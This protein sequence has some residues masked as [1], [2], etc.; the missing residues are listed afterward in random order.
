MVGASAYLRGLSAHATI[1]PEERQPAA[2]VSLVLYVIG[3]GALAVV[4]RLPGVSHKHETVMLLLALGAM[5]LSPVSYQLLRNHRT[6]AW[7]LQLLQCTALATV[8]AAVAASGGA[9]S[10]FWF[11]VFIPAVFCSYFYGRPVAMCYLLACVLVQALPFVY[12]QRAA[13]GLFLA[14]LVAGAPA[15]VALGVSI[16][17]G[18]RR[19]WALRARAEMLASEQFALRRVATAVV[20][21]DAAENIYDMV[22]GEIA[23]LLHCAGAGIMRRQDETTLVVVGSRGDNEGGVYRPGTVVPARPGSDILRALQTGLPVRIDDH[24]DDSPAAAL[25]YRSSIVSPVTVGGGTWGLLAVAD[26]APAAFDAGDELTLSEFGDLLATAIASAEE[27]AQ[28]A[29]QA[30]S[31][32]L[33]GLANQRA[34][35]GRLDAELAR[36]ARHESPLSI[37]LIDI[38]HFKEINDNAGHDIG[39]A[40]L[41][42]V[43]AALNSFARAEDTLARVG[44][45]EFAWVLPDTTREQALVAVER[46]RRLIAAA[47]P[48]PYRITIS[49]GICDTDSAIDPTDLT[50]LADSALYWSKAHGRNQSWIYDPAVVDELTGQQR[51]DRIERSQAIEG[52]RAL[53]RSREA[54]DGATR[55]HSERVATLAGALARRAGWDRSAEL[56]LREAALFHEIGSIAGPGGSGPGGTEL[57]EEDLEGFRGVAELSARIVDGVLDPQQVAWIAGQYARPAAEPVCGPVNGSALLT[58][59]DLWDTMTALRPNSSEQALAECER[60]ADGRLDDRAVGALLALHR[61]GELRP[62]VP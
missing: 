1:D 56:L 13:H 5:V 14:Q 52:L 33:T 23:R 11:Y 45:D 59:A 39:D 2:V 54:R 43:A 27:R 55:E 50:R 46:A 17:S 35:Q 29:E 25:G 62:T 9:T 24:P 51:A 21:G 16:S 28:L 38:D 32:S 36:A 61:D 31:D 58:V 7:A 15:Y 4:A 60:L 34:L 57:G 40:M 19:I 22:A 10:P 20:S 47:P 53:V 8:A 44:G 18:K 49:A 26:P 30:L 48:D 42:R 37:A 41:V 3:G 12:D 6:P